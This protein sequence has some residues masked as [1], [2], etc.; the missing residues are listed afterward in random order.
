M[1]GSSHLT[2]QMDVYAYAVTC[3]EILLMGRMPWPLADD[4]AVR[5]LVLGMLLKLSLFIQAC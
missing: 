1:A 2:P 4:E 5:R 3:A